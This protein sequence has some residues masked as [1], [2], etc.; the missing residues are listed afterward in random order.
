MLIVPLIHV[1]IQQIMYV[2]ATSVKV[3]DICCYVNIVLFYCSK[4]IIVMFLIKFIK[5]KQKI[6]FASWTTHG[7]E[8]PT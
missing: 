4:I 6:L 8:S 3:C 7:R 5:T 2:K 1:V